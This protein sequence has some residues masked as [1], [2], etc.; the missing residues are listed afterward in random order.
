MKKILFLVSIILSSVLFFTVFNFDSA[1]AYKTGSYNFCTVFPAYPDCVGWRTESISD[2]YNYWFCD[3][4][5]LEKLCKNKPDPEKQIMPRNQDFCCRFIGSELE[6]LHNEIQNLSTTNHLFKLGKDSPQSSILP[7]IIWTDKDHYNF[8]DKVTVYGK[9]DFISF[10][11]KKN[12]S[13]NEFDQTGRIVDKNSIQTGRIITK[14]PVLDVDIELNGR[15]VLKNIPV[16]E[17]GWFTTFF[18]LNDRYHFSNRDNFLEVDYILYDDPI[19]F[20]GP[21][22]HAEYHFT[23]GDIA[24]KENSFDISIDDSS[25]PNKIQY[26][27]IVK[28]S[29]RFI[30]LDRYGFVNTRLTTPDGYVIPIKSVFSIQDLSAE[31]SGFSEYGQGTYEIQITYGNNTSKKTFEYINSN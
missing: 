26:R 2:R 29:E 11:I 30:E 8:R 31:Y 27:I 24:K 23:T 5:V 16:H 19:P 10:S 25:L 12:V 28:N 14:S 15:I 7:L 13:D 18:Y 4:V 22:T 17:N 21:K 1:E 3:Y 6:I 9:F 20:G